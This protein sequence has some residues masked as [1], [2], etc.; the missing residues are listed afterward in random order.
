MGESLMAK[1]TK[2]VGI[3]GK[4]G[5]RY[6]ASLRK[7]VKRIEILQHSRYICNFC[8]KTSVKRKEQVSGNAVLA[9]RSWLVAAGSLLQ[10]QQSL[11]GQPSTVSR[12]SVR[13]RNR[14]EHA[15]CHCPRSHGAHNYQSSEEAS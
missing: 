11:S 7:T 2:K 3:A 5:T 10:H 12:N 15:A 6:G 14:S 13:L 4:Y 1:R 8:G 9:R